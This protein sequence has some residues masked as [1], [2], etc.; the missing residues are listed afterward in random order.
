MNRNA[1]IG[2]MLVVTAVILACLV[3]SS[4]GG[5][6]EGLVGKGVWYLPYVALVGGVRALVRARG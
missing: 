3:A 5:V 1:V 6:A 2:L 4:G